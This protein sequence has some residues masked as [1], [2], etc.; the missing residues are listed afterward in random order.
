[1]TKPIQEVLSVEAVMEAYDS[2]PALIK[3]AGMWC[4]PSFHEDGKWCA[5]PASAVASRM[6]ILPEDIDASDDPGDLLAEA[7]DQMPGVIRAFAE[8]VDGSAPWPYLSEDEVVAYYHGKDVREAL[9]LGRVD[10]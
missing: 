8:G 1:M 7:F 6:G 2:N 4:E 3:T 5:C 10:Q 9:G